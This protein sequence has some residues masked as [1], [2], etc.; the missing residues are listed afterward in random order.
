VGRHKIS[1]VP[2]ILMLQACL[3]SLNFLDISL[4]GFNRCFS[5]VLVRLQPVTGQ[6]EL[7]R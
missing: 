4:R 3:L 6:F 1:M 5:F 2:A 7:D